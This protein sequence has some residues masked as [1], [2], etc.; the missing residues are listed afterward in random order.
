MNSSA[1]GGLFNNKQTRRISEM[2]RTQGMHVGEE[3]CM[4]NFNKETW[5]EGRI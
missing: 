5:K 3:K 4:E 2:E 1:T